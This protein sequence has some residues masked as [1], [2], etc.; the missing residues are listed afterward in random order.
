MPTMQLTVCLMGETPVLSA[1]VRVCVQSMISATVPP[2]V[3]TQGSA[4][5]MS[6]IS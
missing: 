3:L 1:V 2:S 6:D 5:L 4:A